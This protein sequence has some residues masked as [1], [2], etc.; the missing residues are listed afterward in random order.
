MPNRHPDPARASADELAV[1]TL[2]VR[3][4]QYADGLGSVDD[5]AEL[6]TADARWLMPGSPRIGREDIRAGSIE[7]RAEGGVGPGSNTRHVIAGTAMSFTT[8]DEAVADSYWM[9]FVNTDTRAEL[10]LIGHYRDVAV[11]TEAGWR[12]SQREITFG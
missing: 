3:L 11:R 6:F 12:I 1:R 8:P 7:R 5:Y 10:R 9:F 2:I 4:A